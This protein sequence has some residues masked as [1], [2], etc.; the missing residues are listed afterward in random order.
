MNNYTLQQRKKII[1]TF[2]EQEISQDKPIKGHLTKLTKDGYKR[3]N[4][5]HIIESIKHVDDSFVTDIT[6]DDIAQ[7]LIVKA[8][9]GLH[10]LEKHIQDNI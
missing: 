9:S 10:N 5:K 8:M 4:F 7:Q 3:W 6:D 2:I 1:T